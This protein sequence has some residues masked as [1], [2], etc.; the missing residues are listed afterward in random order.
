MLLGLG[1][2]SLALPIRPKVLIVVAHPDD[3]YYFAGT[4]YRTAIEKAGVVDELVISNGEGGYRYATLANAIYHLKLDDPKIAESSLPDIREREANAGG[5]IIGIVR[6]IYLRQ[7]DFGFTSSPEETFKRWDRTFV[8][9]KITETLK[10][11][12]YDF[13]WV[14]APIESTHGHHKAASLLALEAVGILPELERPVVLAGI[15]DQV[16]G[17]ILDKDHELEAK[18]G[19]MFSKLP[20]YPI[21]KISE[22]TPTF[23]FNR[24]Q[25]FGFHHQLSYQT[26]I[27]W[28]IAEHKSQGLF[29]SF[30]N[31]DDEEHFRVFAISGETGVKKASEFFRM[32]EAN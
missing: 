23:S 10:A 12:H 18:E 32:L 31:R 29:Q 25:S 22:N 1:N 4:A 8:L 3:E 6:H 7:T 27:N 16:K 17:P 21:S 24:N 26:V 30:M 14:L 9:N 20:S 11:G 19:R 13:V 15:T 28:M 2:T 5:K